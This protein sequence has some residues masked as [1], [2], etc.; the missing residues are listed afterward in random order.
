MVQYDKDR[1]ALTG[2]KIFLNKIIQK[3]FEVLNVTTRHITRCHEK[4]VNLNQ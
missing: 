3:S 1:L 4:V 2:Y